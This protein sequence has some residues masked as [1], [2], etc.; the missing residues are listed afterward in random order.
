MV[1]VYPDGTG[2]CKCHGHPRK[3]IVGL[4]DT[5]IA[6]LDERPSAAIPV[7]GSLDA[8][9]HS[10]AVCFFEELV[11]GPSGLRFWLGPRQHPP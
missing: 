4:L 3:V 10:T 2:E 11:L 8:W 1:A 9:E 5:S 7:K 6:P